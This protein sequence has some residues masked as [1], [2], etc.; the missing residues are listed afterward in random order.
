MVALIH[1]EAAI[2]AAIG[3]LQVLLVRQLAAHLDAGGAP[4]SQTLRL[5]ATADQLEASVRETRRA[6]DRTTK[7]P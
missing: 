6:L 5:H 1:A 2:S 3:D 7:H 4:S